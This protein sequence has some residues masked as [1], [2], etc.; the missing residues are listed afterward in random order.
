MRRLLAGLLVV[1]L[2]ASSA[3]AACPPS[4]LRT[5]IVYGVVPRNLGPEGAS[6][7]TKRLDELKAL[8]VDTLWLSPINATL[9]NDYGYA[10][11]D[12]FALRP[13]FGDMKALHRLV[14]QAHRRRLRVLMDFVPNH[15]SV[16]HPYFRDAEKR[17]RRSPYFA[18][19][20]RDAENRPTHYFD[21]DRLPN[22]N[23]RNGAVRRMVERALV[24]W[25]RDFDVDGFRLDA[26]WAVRARAPRFL[27]SLSRRLR[28]MKP[29]VLLIAEASARDPYFAEHCFDAAYD[30]TSAPGKWSWDGLF[31]VPGRIV[32]RLHA[33]LTSFV[34]DSTRLLRFLNNNDTGARFVARYGAGLTRAAAG[35]LFTL[36]GVPLLFTGDEVGADYLPYRD[37]GPLSFADPLGFR[38]YLQTLIALRRGTPALS[39][40]D[41]TPLRPE[42]GDSFYAYLRWTAGRRSPPVLVAI[43]FANRATTASIALPPKLARGWSMS[44]MRDALTGESFRVALDEGDRLH[45]PLAPFAVRVLRVPVP[46][47]RDFRRRLTTWTCSDSNRTCA[48]PHRAARPP[49]AIRSKHRT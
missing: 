46:K 47:S 23:Y 8:G 28:R 48:D 21:W 19:Y 24:H 1:G 39:S 17:G 18:Y 5:S 45:I 43:N 22:L 49:A 14:R 6:A 41:W 20:E 30:W 13:D 7:V 42:S 44:P 2:S 16:E 12:Y 38:V 25:V 34:G 3:S 36:P 11:T 9:P 29:G 10:V 40:S 26:V 37:Q 15:T 35:L 33:T 31:D 32:E 4:G 27:A